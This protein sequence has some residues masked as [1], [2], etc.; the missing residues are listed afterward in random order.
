MTG[1]QVVSKI[2]FGGVFMVNMLTLK[3]TSIQSIQSNIVYILI[4][5]RPTVP[6][7]TSNQ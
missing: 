2:K 5:F 4:G 3:A 6:K 7:T 1:S